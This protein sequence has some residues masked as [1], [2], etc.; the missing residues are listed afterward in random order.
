MKKLIPLL[1]V[2]IFILSGLGAVAVQNEKQI[3]KN[4]LNTEDWSLEIK[5]KCVFKGYIVTVTN[6]GNESVT[7]N[8]SFNIT[9]DAWIMIR[10]DK[11]SFKGDGIKYNSSEPVEFWMKPLIGFG[12]ATIKIE[13]SWE[14]FGSGKKYYTSSEAKGI[15]LLF[16]VLC[17]LQ[18]QSIP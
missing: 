7:G 2:G 13:F 18:P 15:V 4:P 14:P 11:M 6:V 17:R 8:Y 3:E 16:Y 1:V 9:T 10:G 5:V 12:P